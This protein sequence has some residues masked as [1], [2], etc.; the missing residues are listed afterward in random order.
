MPRNNSL[1]ARALA[2]KSFLEQARELES[3]IA[4][5]KPEED[6]VN[7]IVAEILESSEIVAEQIVKDEEAFNSVRD[8]DRED[9]IDDSHREYEDRDYDIDG[10]VYH[11]F[12]VPPAE[13]SGLAPTDI[14]LDE[15]QAEAVRQLVKHQYACLI[16]AAGTGK[17]TVQKFVLQELIYGVTESGG[18][19]IHVRQ[20]PGGQG[21][22]I[23][24]IAFTG[25]ASQ[26]IKYNQPDWM[27][28]ACKTIHG[29]L[30]FKPEETISTKTGKK[31]RIF[32]P[33]RHNTNKCEHDVVIIDEASMV[34][35]DLWKQLLAAL[36]PGTRVYMTGDLNQL[37]PIIGQPVFAYALS[38]WPVFELT[39]VH[40][41][42]E[43]G[44]NRIVEVAHQVLNGK[45]PTFDT[46]KDNPDWRVAGFELDGNP[47]KAQ[48]QILA[49]LQQV[50][51]RRIDESDPTSPLVYDPYR[52]RVMTAGNGFDD[53][54]DTSMVQQAPLNEA[55]SILIQ[56]PKEGHVRYIIDAGRR[57]PKFGVGL[58]V[59][60]TKNEAPD[61]DERVTNGMTGVIQDIFRNVKYSG[62]YKLFGAEDE[63]QVEVR[64]RIAHINLGR[65]KALDDLDALANTDFDDI[66]AEGF[67][68]EDDEEDD[69]EGGGLASHSVV[70]K[71][72]NGASRTFSSKAGVESLHLAFCSTVAKCQGSQFDTAIIIVHHGQ[73]QQ[74]CREW[75]YTAITRAT[76]RVIILYT[77]S[78]LNHAIQKQK[79]FGR[80]IAEKVE[81]Y[82]KMATE[83]KQ[84]APGVRLR[85]N[86]PLSIEEFD[87]T[88]NT[89]SYEIGNR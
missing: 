50:R 67:N 75:L 25:M 37:P 15:S 30:E 76:K 62:D 17:T 68:H 32:V 49:I 13:S 47:R 51:T 74:L 73:K 5:T 86:V 35:L 34:G 70:V 60:A 88:Q 41:Q 42:K 69:A 56:P 33:T 87:D 26:V 59:M 64:T 79:I 19:I 45:R 80:T 57:Q 14:E 23:A 89:F 1:F 27:G 83:G 24:L 82:R 52:D 9:S 61:K 20:L 78:G 44:A 16:G 66:N 7:E 40:R 48:Q 63:V 36:K 71:F 46:T 65:T 31:T 43:A 4:L 85:V 12:R 54:V 28:A 8:I 72:D 77:T 39:K 11:G 3:T 18:N 21:L 81:S 55:L 6:K 2:R 29:F 58:R 22:N 38:R 84:V 53:S 10:A